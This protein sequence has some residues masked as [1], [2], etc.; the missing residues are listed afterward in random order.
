MKVRPTNLILEATGA[1]VLPDPIVHRRAEAM[2]SERW[3][4]GELKPIY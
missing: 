3:E 2:V 4:G 1:N